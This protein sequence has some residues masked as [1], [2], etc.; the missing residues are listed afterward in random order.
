MASHRATSGRRGGAKTYA[1]T[2]QA[3]YK[4]GSWTGS[5]GL[6]STTI[7]AGSQAGAERKARAFY[8][9]EWKGEVARHREA[10]V[11]ARAA[12]RR[13]RGSPLRLGR[14]DKLHIVV[15]EI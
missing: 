1:A 12:G 7:T 3:V 6:R 15:V 5:T 9:K 11:E 14:L 2:A 4:N 8:A 10:I 13:K